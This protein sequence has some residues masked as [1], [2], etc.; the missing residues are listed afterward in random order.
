MPN[1][2]IV[3]GLAG[4]GKSTLAESLAKHFG[5][6]C[7]HASDI[8]R[9][10]RD[11]KIDEIRHEQTIPGSGWWE[12]VEGKAYLE[13]R[14]HDPSMDKALDKQLLKIAEA[15][16]VVFD[17][18]TM[19]WLCKQGFKIWLEAPLDVRAQRVSVRDNLSYEIVK[20]R[21]SEKDMKTAMIYK[22][23]YGFDLGKDFK[24]FHLM[25]KTENLSAD[26]V[27][28]RV[29]AAIQKNFATKTQKKRTKKKAKRKSAKKKRK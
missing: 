15:G 3:S 2:I 13:K 19:P 1:L 10:L 9:Q 21:L 4:S 22:S 28:E 23:I 20:E 16:K 25:L 7:I 29:K 6:K 14:L 18:W 17:S 8:L 12:S 26:D 5:L 27:F 11:K 24:P